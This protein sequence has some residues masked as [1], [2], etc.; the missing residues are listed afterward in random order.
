MK[1][2]ILLISA[3][4][5]LLTVIITGCVKQSKT[6]SSEDI[7]V[8]RDR[9]LIWTV[10]ATPNG[11]DSEYH[12]SLQALEAQSNMYDSALRY[13]FKEDESG[14]LVPDY[15]KVESSLAE[16]WELSKDGK[17]LTVHLRQGVKSH[18]GNEL[19]ADDFMY[20]WV[21]RAWG[22]NAMYKNFSADGLKLNDPE[23][24]LKKIDKY[25]FSL[26]VDTPNPIAEPMMTH[27]FTHLMDSVDAKAYSTKSDP[28]AT[29]YL[30][31]NGSGHG[32]FK[33]TKY[34]PGQQVEFEAFN[35]Y[36]DKKNKSWFQKVI[37]KEVPSSSNRVALL[38]SGTA[39]AATS[40]TPNELQ[41]LK[42]K[43]GVKVYSWSGNLIQ[44]VEFNQEKPP[45]DN[46]KVRKALAYA[47]PYKDIL[48]SV[49]LGMAKQATSIIPSTYPGY[50]GEYWDY[51]TNFDKAKKLLKEAG[52]D[53]GFKT[54]LT[55]NAG[56]T[57]E[58][59]IAILLKSSF[60][61][62]GVEIEIQEL[63]TGD[64]YNN[65]VQHNM[66]GM[67]IFQDMPGVADG[68]FS[69]KLWAQHPSNINYGGYKNEEVNRLYKETTET[70]DVKKRN[71]NFKRIQEIVVKEDPIWIYLTEPGY[72][73]AMRED[74]KNPA[75]GTSQDI[76]WN[77][78]SRERN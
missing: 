69:T 57:Q 73:I 75:W 62:I 23:K 28:W 59:Q 5:L 45:F 42:G 41:T 14:F 67:F 48:S 53:K 9:T 1:R 63:Q 58:Q 30:S 18:A 16:S 13:P 27:I 17:T 21:D 19:T 66:D 37:M 56:I 47:T 36:W 60:K 43:P 29:K 11:L 12:N 2:I 10:P 65:L 46:P 40:L 24:Q 34:I 25:T 51:K 78:L 49:Y 35:D 54:T 68:G 8:D 74:I 71:A 4:I 39:D 52:Y 7:N 72:H 20:Q 38:L 3:L 22:L 61:N 55:I 44:R 15:S 70:L 50:T 31:V 76:R 26:T 64:Y 32:P 6:V 77:M 33:V